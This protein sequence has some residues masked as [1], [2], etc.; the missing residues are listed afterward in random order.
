MKHFTAI[1]LLVSKN[2][3]FNDFSY[4]FQCKFDVLGHFYPRDITLKT[5]YRGHLGD[6][7]LII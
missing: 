7:K 1:G 3:N 4:I 6:A 5:L 2:K